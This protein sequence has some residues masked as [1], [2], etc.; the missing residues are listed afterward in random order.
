MQQL[1]TPVHWPTP[2][3][4]PVDYMGIGTQSKSKYMGWSSELIEPGGRSSQRLFC[5]ACK[6]S[7]QTL[8]EV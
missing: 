5:Y 7:E 8:E 4:P 3:D 6:S 2:C 1:N